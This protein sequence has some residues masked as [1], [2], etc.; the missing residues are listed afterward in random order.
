MT[1]GI[2]RNKGIKPAQPAPAGPD[3]RTALDQIEAAAANLVQA[4]TTLHER[5]LLPVAE[6][7][8]YVRVSV[9]LAI[10][11][12]LVAAAAAFTLTTVA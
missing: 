12:V 2:G 5:S 6:V 8:W 7:R 3:M 10:A 1:R 4:A 9:A 11:S